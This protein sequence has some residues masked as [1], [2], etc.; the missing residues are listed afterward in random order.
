MLTV[1]SRTR[2]REPDEVGG[3]MPTLPVPDRL[4]RAMDLDLRVELVPQA[5][6]A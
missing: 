2:M 4:A 1:F 6:S 3:T 5:E